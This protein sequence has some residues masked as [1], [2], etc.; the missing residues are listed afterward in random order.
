M[1]PSV[2]WYDKSRI[3]VVKPLESET[4][5]VVSWW[6]II[7]ILFSHFSVYFLML[8][9][10]E[11]IICSILLIFYYSVCCN[12]HYML[13]LLQSTISFEIVRSVSSAMESL[14]FN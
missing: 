10:V 14:E 5:N 4:K 13:L 7:S 11:T 9:M 3:R 2:F 8:I 6:T 1:Y 12:L